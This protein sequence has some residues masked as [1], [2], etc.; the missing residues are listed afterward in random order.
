MQNSYRSYLSVIVIG[1]LLVAFYFGAM[2][3]LVLNMQPPLLPNTN[4]SGKT[5]TVK[6]LLYMSEMPNG[7]FGFGTA[8]DNLSSPGPTLRLSTSEIV[9]I[10]V[11]NTGKLPHA[12]AI[13]TEPIA[14]AAVLFNSAIGSASNPLGPGQ[15]GSVVFKPNNAGFSYC[16]MSPV[17]GDVEAG[18]YGTVTI[19]TITGYGS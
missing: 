2:L 4:I 17:S 11:V 18:M 15:Q 14:G 6:V 7:K 19:S 9:N 3:V 5:P 13:T 8:L 12:F 16:Y 1:V 10:T